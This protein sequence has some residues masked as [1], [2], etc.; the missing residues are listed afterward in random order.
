MY[1]IC[2]IGGGAAGMAAAISAAE[3]NRKLNIL[4]LEKKEK[5]GR[6]IIASGNGKCNLSNTACQGY[7]DIRDFFGSLG[8]IIREDAEGRVYPYTEDSKSVYEALK[9]RM[10][11]TGV[12]CIT[13]AEVVSVDKDGY[14]IIRTATETFTSRKL[15]LATG[16]KSAPQFGTTGD[17]YR[18]AKNFGHHIEKLIPVLTAVDTVEDM[19]KFAGIRAKGQVSLKYK[20]N[21][22][23]REKGEIQ[24]TKTGISGICVFNLSRFLLIP[25]GVSFKEG[26]NDYEIDIDF[27]SDIDDIDTFLERRIELEGFTE[28]NVLRFLVKDAIAERITIMAKENLHEMGRLLKA[29]PVRPKTVRG[30][31]FAQVTKGGVALNEINMETMESII[32]KDLYFAGEIMDFDGPCGGFNLQNAWETGIKAG[33]GMANGQI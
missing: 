30:W 32:C 15:L 5:P 13:D 1:D 24:F 33:K 10:E 26:F 4:L 22:T 28:K 6:K 9:G 31:N 2:I 27:L 25:E 20:E 11:Y 7:K 19:E 18:W 21:I 23:F 3:T 29:Y 8:L 16:G 12:K 17:G 14:F